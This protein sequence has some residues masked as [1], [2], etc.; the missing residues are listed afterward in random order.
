[1]VIADF[2]RKEKLGLSRTILQKLIHD[3][4]VLCAKVAVTKPHYKVKEAEEVQIAWEEKKKVI[5]QPIKVD[6]EIIYQDDDVAV[7]NKPAGM[8]VHPGAGTHAYTLVNVLLY[9]FKTLSD[10]NSQ[11]PGIMH[12]LDKDTSG[13][14]VI[15]KNNQAHLLL[16]KQFSEHTIR[17]V[18]IAIVKGKVEFDE[19]EIEI[20]IGRHPLKRK[21][22]SAQHTKEAKY[23]KT[24]YRTLK[25][26]DDYS[27]L[28]LYPQ[29]GRTH[30]LRVHLAFIG[31]P[32]LGDKVYGKY[33]DFSRLAL[34]AKSIGFIHPR[35]GKFVEFTSE[36]PKEFAQ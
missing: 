19:G 35:T 25:R 3:G 10:I 9:H 20:P 30:Q 33:N 32:I 34:H 14:M 29:T 18:Y 8:V 23:A 17:K 6:L 26:T 12:R 5:Q 28:E 7:I 2:A 4:S 22:M 11:R 21:Q 1:M 27:L 36:V 15:A 31:H 13:I 24:N 16:S